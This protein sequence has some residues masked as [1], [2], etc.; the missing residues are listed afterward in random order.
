[1]FLKVLPDASKVVTIQNCDAVGVNFGR[2]LGSEIQ[3]T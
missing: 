2:G 3:A 1:M